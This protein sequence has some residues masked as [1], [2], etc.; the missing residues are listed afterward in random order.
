M[1]VSIEITLTP[2]QDDYELA[3]KTFI[4]KLRETSFDVH[5]NPLSTQVYGELRPLMDTLT[6]LIEESFDAI[7][8]G[9]IHLKI[10]KT[11]RSNYVPFH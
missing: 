9:M 3:I 8:A 1:K 10:V 6:L 2:L 11:D 4:R 7:A 5:E